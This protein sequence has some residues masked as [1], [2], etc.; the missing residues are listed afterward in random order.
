VTERP[1]SNTAIGVA[2][3]R[4][5]HQ[6]IDQPPWI[7]DD[8]IVLRLLGPTARERVLDNA[9]RFRSPRAVGLRAHVLL[10]SRYAEECLQAAVNRGTTQF[11]VLGAGMDTFAFRQ[12]PWASALRIFEVDHPA[13]QQ[14]KRDRLAAA[15]ISAPANL[16]F[17]PV[18]FEHETI[19]ERLIEQEFDFSALTFVSCLGVLVYLSNEAVIDLFE[20]LG[21]LSPASGC[22]LTIGGGAR[23]KDPNVPS[24][25]DLAA[26]VGEPFLSALDADALGALCTR[27]GLE[28]PMF[29]TTEEIGRYMGNRNDGLNAPTRRNIASIMVA[30]RPRLSYSLPNANHPGP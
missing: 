13:S 25:A 19:R 6:L 16:T 24:L 27:F 23:P 2:T 4:A 22:V 7:L 3:L 8:P 5:A 18:D 26:E 11:L 14:A 12:P 1:A 17:V 20:F 21:S 9:E 28:Q 10:R 29:P 15:G 30:E